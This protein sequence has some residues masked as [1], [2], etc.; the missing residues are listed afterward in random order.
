MILYMKLNDFI[1]LYMY[2]ERKM[3]MVGGYLHENYKWACQ[4]WHM[5]RT[6]GGYT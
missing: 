3:L 2:I 4:D 6:L 5:L 1:K